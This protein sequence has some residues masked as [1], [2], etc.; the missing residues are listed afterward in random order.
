MTQP[1]LDTADIRRRN[2]SAVL[3]HVIEQGAASRSGIADAT[4]LSRGAV[5]SLV[6]DLTAAGLLRER[7]AVAAAKGRPRVLLEPAADDLC[8]IAALLDADRATVVA[9]TLGGVELLR[10]QRRHGRPMG[11]PDAIAAV[12]AATIDEVAAAVPRRITDLAI[13]VWAP[14]AGTPPVVLADTDLQWGEVDLIALTRAGS[15]A[16]RSFEAHG[17]SVELI[18]DSEVAALAEHASA[19]H[20]DGMLYLKADSG[21]G[22]AIVLGART[23]RVIGAALGHQPIIPDGELCECGQHGCLVTVAG[24]DVL[25]AATG[26]TDL[27]TT[28]GL[29]A[30]L[31]EFTTRVRA[32]DA[33][34]VAA[35]TPACAE[36]ARAVQISATAF[37]PETIVLGGF[38]AGLAAD[39][40]AVL[41]SIQPHIA[42]AR[43]LPVPRVV[44]SVL[45]ADAALLGAQRAAR[46]RVIADPL[47]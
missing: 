36:V 7:E 44:G 38:Y 21:V 41:R 33:R 39:V 15:E 24:P 2:L 12:L 29:D 28:E 5:T 1:S 47:H 17:G 40:E 45:G 42:Q 11:D 14:V 13:V 35:W 20:P 31:A 37:W 3:G 25:L 32:G 22:G 9:S 8:L 10:V 23:P 4:A 16:V 26:L 46:A 18:A 34:A 30:A 19:G 27:A 6:V 43:A